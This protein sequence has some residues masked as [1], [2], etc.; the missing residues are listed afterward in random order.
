[1]DV[2]AP[3]MALPSAEVP[4]IE[5]DLVRQLRELA[6]LKWGTRRIAAALGIHRDTVR[7][8]LRGGAEALVQTRPAARCLDATGEARARAL[9]ASAAEGNAQVVCTLLREEGYAASLRTVQRIL[10][11][12]R[13]QVRAAQLATVRVE[14]EPGRQMQI[15]FGQKLVAIGGEMV[16]VFLL[17]AVL[18]FSRRLFVK[19]FLAERGDDWREGIAAAF[20]HF[21][22]VPRELLGD[23]ASALVVR[24]DRATRTVVFHPAYLAFCKDWDVIPRACAPYRARTK[25]KTESGVKFVKHN[26]LAGRPFESFAHLE[27]HLS[28]WMREA[29]ARDHG[30]THERPLDRFERLER[31]ALR[32]LPAQ[33][34]PV[35]EQRLKRRVSNDAFVDVDTVRYSVPHQL[36]RLH[37]EV[38]VGTDQVIVFRGTERVATHARSTEPHARVEDPAHRVGLWRS[39][40]ETPDR[41]TLAAL[42]RSLAA[43][44]AV[45]AA[46]GAR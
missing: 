39:P 3:G 29:D 4:V 45:V 44:E 13:Q 2:Q 23:N 38:A 32:P 12:T 8:Y 7:R 43:Y 1:M 22:G 36:I 41:A 19:A 42:G 18:S 15:D 21:G 40:A 25:G 14:T 26:G 34:L 9:F 33:P 6:A 31:A 27:A 11:P 46:G 35:R 37:V 17:V 5:T 30:T 28:E 24:H 10:Q 20:R 16:R